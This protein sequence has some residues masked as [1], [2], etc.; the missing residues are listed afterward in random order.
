MFRSTHIKQR[1][2]A[3]TFGLKAAHSVTQGEITGLNQIVN[4]KVC[5]IFPC[6][7]PSISLFANKALALL[8]KLKSKR[9]FSGL[10]PCCKVFIS[11]LYYSLCYFIAFFMFC[12]ISL[13]ATFFFIAKAR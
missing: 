6:F 5:A 11:H 2:E 4:V 12:S 13:V 8:P 1:Y 7:S 3:P 9:I 10:N